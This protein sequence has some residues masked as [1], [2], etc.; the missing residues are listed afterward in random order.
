MQCK[1]TWLYPFQSGI[2]SMI[3]ISHTFCITYTAKVL[4]VVSFTNGKSIEKDVKYL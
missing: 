1:I 3:D 2:N 4:N